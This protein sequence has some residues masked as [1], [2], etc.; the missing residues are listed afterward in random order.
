MNLCVAQVQTPSTQDFRN[1][2]A[3]RCFPR[4]T[5]NTHVPSAATCTT[6]DACVIA[7]PGDPAPCR[8]GRAQNTAAIVASSS[9]IMPRRRFPRARRHVAGTESGAP[10]HADAAKPTRASPSTRLKADVEQ[11]QGRRA[12]LQQPPAHPDDGLLD[13]PASYFSTAR[14]S[15]VTPAAFQCRLE[16]SRRRSRARPA[17]HR[18]DHAWFG[19]PQRT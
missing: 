18:C 15:A 5:R 7:R 9:L 17:A 16:T 13:V 12:R 10:A 19:L 3:P 14:Q 1:A 4:D 8:H 2:K 6:S 11:S